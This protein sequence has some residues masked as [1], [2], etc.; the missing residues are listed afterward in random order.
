[1]VFPPP[2]PPVIA[3]NPGPSSRTA[4]SRTPSPRNRSSSSMFRPYESAATTLRRLAGVEA[5]RS[6]VLD[7]PA[8]TATRQPDLL[9]Q[10]VGERRG[11]QTHQ[12]D[13]LTAPPDL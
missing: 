9:H 7:P 1:M 2:V 6:V 4:S 11:P 13:R 3:V 5:G 8:P 12:A 10:P